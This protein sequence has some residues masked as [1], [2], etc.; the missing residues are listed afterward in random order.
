MSEQLGSVFTIGHSTH[1][2]EAFVALLKQHGVTALADVRSAPFSRFNPQFNR[3]AL[4][5]GDIVIRPICRSP[6][7]AVANRGFYPSGNARNMLGGKRLGQ[8]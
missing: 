2:F 1:S 4:E 5:Q 8:E 3:D 6:L 7:G